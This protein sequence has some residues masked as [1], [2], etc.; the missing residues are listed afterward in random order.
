MI[1]HRRKTQAQS[2][3][4]LTMNY[5]IIQQETGYLIHQLQPLKV[6]MAYLKQIYKVQKKAD[7]RT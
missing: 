5:C 4:F 7:G 2:D 3:Y 1:E 6:I